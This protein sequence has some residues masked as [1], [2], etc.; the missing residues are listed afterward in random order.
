MCEK[1]RGSFLGATVAQCR[2][3][4]DADAGQRA[5]FLA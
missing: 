4:D 5:G 2:C 1:F 3:R